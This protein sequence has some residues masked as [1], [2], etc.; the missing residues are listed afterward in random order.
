[1]QVDTEETCFFISKL[2]FTIDATFFF[3]GEAGKYLLLKAR[4]PQIY[5]G[6]KSGLQQHT[7]LIAGFRAHL[8]LIRSITI[9]KELE[10]IKD[11]K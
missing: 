4:S 11:K 9:R 10:H 2:L 5:Q 3:P 8:C 6:S 7:K 1:M